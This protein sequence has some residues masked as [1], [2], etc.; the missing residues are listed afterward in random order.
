MVFLK[1]LLSLMFLKINF[2]LEGNWKDVVY[3]V[4]VNSQLLWI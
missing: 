1:I 3:A 4:G 2:C